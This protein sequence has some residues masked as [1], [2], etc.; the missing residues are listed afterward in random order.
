MLLLHQSLK[1]DPAYLLVPCLWEWMIV[2]YRRYVIAF[3]TDIK[4]H[5]MLGY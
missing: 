5:S 4:I 2:Q 3:G 1:L